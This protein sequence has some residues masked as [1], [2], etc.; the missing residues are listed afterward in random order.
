MHG[1]DSALPTGSASRRAGA[2]GSVSN[3]DLNGLD[4]VSLDAVPAPASLALL[5]LGLLGVGML[6]R[7][8][9]K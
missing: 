4:D 7:R 8:S 3:D 2:P 1:K 9:P 6:R 5:G